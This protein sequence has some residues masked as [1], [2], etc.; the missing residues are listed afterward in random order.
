MGIGHS[1]KDQTTHIHNQILRIGALC[2]GR[3]MPPPPRD[4]QTDRKF[5]HRADRTI[6]QEIAFDLI[7]F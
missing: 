1:V 2:M 6:D 3:H 7:R 5:E 4:K